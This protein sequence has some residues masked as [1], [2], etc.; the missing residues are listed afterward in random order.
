LA[1][2]FKRGPAAVRQQRASREITSRR[3]VRSSD[4]LGATGFLGLGIAPGLLE[5]VDKLHFTEPTPIQK[6]S[7]PLVLE[8]NDL[9]AI[10]QTGTGKTLAFGIPMLQ[11]LAGRSG[12]GLVLVPTRELALQVEEA[13]TDVGKAQNMRTAVLIGGASIVVQQRA[14]ARKPRIIVA[15]PGRLIDHVEKRNVDLGDVEILVLDEADRMLDMGFAPQIKRILTFVPKNRQTMLFSATMPGMIVSIARQH[16]KHPVHVEIAQSGTTVENVVQEVFFVERREKT[17]LLDVQLKKHP[18]PALVFTR[19]KN[20]AAVLVRQVRQLG[21]AATSIHSNKTQPQRR[22]AL[23]GFK[24]GQY[25]VLVATDIASRGIDVQGIA[26]VVNYDLPS[27]SEDYV[28][29]IGRTARAG[30]AGRAI[31]FATFNQTLEVRDIENLTRTALPVTPLPEEFTPPLVIPLPIKSTAPKR[32]FG[33]RQS[34][35]SSRM[36]SRGR[37]RR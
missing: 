18:G 19:T 36:G 34:R 15:T 14:L 4:T 8:G 37:R 5:A 25:R 6:K 3:D 7:I 23:D 21:Y 22:K 1:S 33:V 30:R 35:P 20:G 29:R 12:K 32:A 11:R 24:S 17:S 10:A 13:I 9:I 16:M 26:I 2:L 27:N 28:H 31:S